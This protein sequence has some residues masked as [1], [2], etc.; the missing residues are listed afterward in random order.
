MQ[1]IVTG[2]EWVLLLATMGE[3]L[4]LQFVLMNLCCCGM[5]AL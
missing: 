5:Q 2:L 1:K 4:P 3:C